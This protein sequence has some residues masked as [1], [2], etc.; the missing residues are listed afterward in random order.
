LAGLAK[1][2]VEKLM[3]KCYK[4][5]LMDW[6]SKYFDELYARFFLEG[7]SE[8]RTSE[9]VSFIIERTGLSEGSAVAD[10]GCGL[11][12]HVLECARRGFIATGF[13]FNESYIGKAKESACNEN[14]A[15]AHF[16]A[17]DARNF[18][19]VSRFDLVASLWV[20]FGYFDDATNQRILRQMARSLKPGGRM[21]LDL[22][23]REYILRHFVV[24]KHREKDGYVILERSRFDPLTS[25]NRCSRTIIE[26][27]GAR[28]RIAREVRL[29]TLTEMAVMLKSAGIEL[30]DV[31]G[32]W[33][34]KAY[35]L[36]VPRMIIFGR[37][38]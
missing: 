2:K 21:A 20:S 8:S 12:R 14:L 30:Q 13:D 36:E 34:G 18:G 31:Y 38:T 33:D 6:T 11:G 16:V 9:Q 22:E 15:N 27:D 5:E 23:N 25:I 10:I 19:E 24:D 28:R 32:D 3:K 1:P 37:L 29:Y 17:Q 7:V 35:G 4:L 26:P